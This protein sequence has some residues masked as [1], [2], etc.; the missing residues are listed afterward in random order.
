MKDGSPILV[1]EHYITLRRENIGGR[2]SAEKIVRNLSPKASS[3]M[4]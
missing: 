3:A 4:E 1:P 2:M